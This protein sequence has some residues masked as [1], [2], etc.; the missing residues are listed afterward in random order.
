MTSHTFFDVPSR[1]LKRAQY[2]AF[3]FAYVDGDIRVRNQSHAD[4]ENHEYIVA[5]D[6]GRPVACSCPADAKYDHPCKHR[7]ALSIR[8][9]ILEFVVATEAR[10]AVEPE[11]RS[12]HHAD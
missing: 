3:D 2:E 1:I 7:V 11:N 5:I 10:E 6:A 8:R 12:R 4:P 9:P